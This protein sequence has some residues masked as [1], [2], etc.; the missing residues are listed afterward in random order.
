MHKLPIIPG[1]PTI[2]QSVHSVSVIKECSFSSVLNT[3]LHQGEAVVVSIPEMF[4]TKVLDLITLAHRKASLPAQKNWDS[5]PAYSRVLVFDKKTDSWTF[6]GTKQFAAVP[7]GD[8]L[9]EYREED[10]PEVEALHDW[11]YYSGKLLPQAICIINSGK[12]VGATSVIHSLDMDFFP[13]D[14]TPKQTL[15]FS[16]GTAFADLKHKSREQFGGGISFKGQYPHAVLLNSS[17]KPSFLLSEKGDNYYVKD[18]SL[19]IVVHHEYTFSRV[20]VAVGDTK[21]TGIFN[22]DGHFGTLGSAK[23]KI[24]LLSR[25]HVQNLA[26]NLNIPPQGVLKASANKKLSVSPGDEFIISAKIDPAYV[27]GVRIQ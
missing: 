1:D 5:E 21:D 27:M 25:N 9:A 13:E 14:T 8:K 20:E 23:L 24:D 7:F 6:W 11:P 15:I 10:N 17:E 19:H 3:V 12:G 4:H 18:K 22:K 16:P 2:I 26:Q